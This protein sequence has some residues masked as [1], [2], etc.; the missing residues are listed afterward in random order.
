MAEKMI[1]QLPLDRHL[2]LPRIR[3]V[4]LHEL[5]GLPILGK[6]HLLLRALGRVQMPNPTLEGAQVPWLQPAARAF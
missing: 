5:S 1:Q 6:E 2:Q 4:Q 3:P